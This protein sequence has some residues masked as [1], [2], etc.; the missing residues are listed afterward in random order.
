MKHLLTIVNCLLAL[1]LTAQEIVV[2]YPYNPDVDSDEVVGTID[3]LELLVL[4]GLEFESDSLEIN[5]LPLESYLETLSATINELQISMD[6]MGELIYIESVLVD[7]ENS[8]LFVF[9]DGS[10]FTSPTIEGPQGE[11]GATG[12][13][14]PA[15]PQ[16]EV[17]VTG[18][19]GPQGVPGPQ[20][21][22]GSPGPDGMSAYEIWLDQGNNGSEEDFLNSLAFPVGDG[23]IEAGSVPFWNG[24]AWEF[25]RLVS[26]WDNQA[27]NY[28]TSFP[29]HSPNACVYEE[30]ECGIC[31]GS[32]IPFGGSG[33]PGAPCDDG[34]AL[35]FGDVWSED[36]Q[37]CTGNIAIDPSGLG[38]CSGQEFISYQGYDYPLVEIASKCWFQENLRA[39]ADRYGV[40]LSNLSDSD[41]WSSASGPGYC[42]PYNETEVDQR[43]LIYNAYTARTNEV[44]PS[45]WT[46]LGDGPWR[47]F[48]EEL[49]FT[50]YETLYQTW[51]CE[52]LGD[53]MKSN[54]FG[55]V[56]WDGTNQ[57]GFSAIPAPVRTN[58][59]Q[60]WGNG[61]SAFFW[62]SNGGYGNYG[63]YHRRLG[64]QEARVLRDYN[65]TPMHSNN[66]GA[67]I[68][69]VKD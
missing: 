54:S 7:D 9:N 26:C 4:F 20:G 40:E 39:T 61:N 68:R 19:Q 32:G 55:E 38:P 44:C 50:Q 37:E 52:P 23:L 48:E 41:D 35:T 57:T 27:C 58:S 62:T 3:L 5:G 21:S 2:E 60:F 25:I 43:G 1:N 53:W 69:C 6:S 51:R 29:V 66:H 15:G 47:Q 63:P 13:Q 65:H 36:G 17:G 46:V 59:G 10:S 49:G 33:C 12:P 30:D 42:A 67:A 56:S 31:G 11:V 34:D 28:D 45:G 8:L 16:G 24:Q 22:S 64:T 18:P 14:G